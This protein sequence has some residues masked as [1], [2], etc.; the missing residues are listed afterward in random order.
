MP[1]LSASVVGLLNA[2]RS[3]TETAIPSAPRSIA[4]RIA[5]T[6]S[7]TSLRFE[8]VHAWLAP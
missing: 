1:R 8:P 6:I 4:R 7:P 5:L 2:R 3:I